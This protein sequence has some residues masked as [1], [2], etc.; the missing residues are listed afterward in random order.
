[1]SSIVTCD[2][3][4]KEFEIAFQTEGARGVNAAT[5]FCWRADK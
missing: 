3:C 5:L 1:M 2:G 4:D